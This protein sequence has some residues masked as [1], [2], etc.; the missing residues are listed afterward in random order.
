[1]EIEQE[2]QQI[3]NSITN[4]LAKDY[5]QNN[6]RIY[7]A[8]QN[9][10]LDIKRD[11]Y[12]I[13]VLGE[14]KRGKSTFINA[15]L[16][17]AIL[18]MDVL[19]ETATIN[20]IMYN[21][22]PVLKVVYNDGNEVE[23]E[24]SYEYLANF[25]AQKE[26]NLVDK[27]KYLKLGYPLDLLEN[28]IVLVDTP[29]VSDMDEQRCDVTYRFLPTANAVIFLLDAN[30]PLKKTEVDFINNKIL[31]LGVTNILFLLNKYDCVDE[32]EEDD[33]LE[34]VQFK[35]D[36][37]FGA[38]NANIK[39][40][41]VSAR[42]A[43]QGIETN[44]DRLIE[45]SN[46]EIVHEKL[47]DMIF[48]GDIEQDK[49][50]NYK[51]TLYNIIGS[52]ERELINTQRIKTASINELEAIMSNLNNLIAE[53]EQNKKNINGYIDKSKQK[54]YSM[55]YK[56]LKSFQT[57]LEDDIVDMIETYRSE[58]FKEF[59]EKNVTKRI[60]K[61]LESWVGL[62][63]PRIDLLIKQ[64]ERELAHGMS[65]YFN[66]RIRMYTQ[67][68]TELKS[69]KVALNIEANDISD[70]TWKS[71][72]IAAAGSVGIMAVFGGVVLPLIGFA[73]LPFLRK[74]MLKEKLN[75][76]KEQLIPE[77]KAQINKTILELNKEICKY[78]DNRCEMICTNT[79]YTYSQILL[80]MKNDINI[81]I[82]KK[83]AKEEQTQLE[84]NKIEHS[85]LE[86]ETIKENLK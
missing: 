3:R 81:Q 26:N 20:A 16:R 8:L 37:F 49:I 69:K 29:G 54:I 18:P 19:P 77:I 32:E 73:A 43:L 7:E 21:E 86:I 70:V 64:L 12:T 65:Y 53:K 68:G 72:A 83:R 52:L 25:S 82:E 38:K 30:S 15:L 17:K 42:Q 75:E 23:G 10:N 78:V 45:E 46:I 33:L 36:K 71:G 13:L 31:P 4:L 48:H 74:Q 44:N 22:N 39:V 50:R 61:S 84:I 41:P 35:L 40:Y 51:Y 76:A 9:L 28:R 79:E 58:D 14:F 66:Q 27:I 67:A 2:K 5:V 56:S 60:Q 47:K 34:D 1:M 24:V 63:E 57:K 11:F 85:L 55:T 62:Y 6:K 59:V 80:N